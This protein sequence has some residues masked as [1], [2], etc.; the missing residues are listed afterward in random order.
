MARRSL[1]HIS[2]K[3]LEQ[4]TPRTPAP[5]HPH[6]PHSNDPADAALS[7]YMQGLLGMGS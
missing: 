3:K 6:R 7:A 5:T 2:G 4:S 1:S